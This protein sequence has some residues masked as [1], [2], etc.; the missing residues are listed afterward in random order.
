MGCGTICALDRVNVTR[1]MHDARL[2]QM[3]VKT[4]TSTEL[5]RCK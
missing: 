2:C 1:L 4:I 3:G 5:E